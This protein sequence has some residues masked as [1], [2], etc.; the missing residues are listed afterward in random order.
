MHSKYACACAA[1]R[2]GAT[3]PLAAVWS[4]LVSR[5]VIL[6]AGR[7]AAVCSSSPGARGGRR[8]TKGILSE[9]IREYSESIPLG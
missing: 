7:G 1:A 3:A 8:L 4:S 6:A 9:S 2:D 5:A